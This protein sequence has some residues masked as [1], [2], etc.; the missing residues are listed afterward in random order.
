MLRNIKDII[1]LIKYNQKLN[2]KPE[3]ID[4]SLQYLIEDKDYVSD[5]SFFYVYDLIC[6]RM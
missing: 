1:R 4:H 6:S 2:E 3:I 5:G